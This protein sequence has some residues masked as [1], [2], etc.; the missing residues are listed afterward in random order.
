MVGMGVTDLWLNNFP[1]RLSRYL[2]IHYTS[3]RTKEIT[4]ISKHEKMGRS[5]INNEPYIIK[6][7]HITD[8]TM[9]HIISTNILSVNKQAI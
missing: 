1:P 7:T 2:E 5:G 4:D 9:S 8:K 6:L 3:L